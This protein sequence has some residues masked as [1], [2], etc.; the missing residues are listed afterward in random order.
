LTNKSSQEY[1]APNAIKFY[2]KN[3]FVCGVT[4]KTARG[5]KGVK[6]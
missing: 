1:I 4:P 6:P 3:L 2:F 5:H